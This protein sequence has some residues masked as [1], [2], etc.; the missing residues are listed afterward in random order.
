LYKHARLVLE[1]AQD[2][3][4]L[5]RGAI[6]FS[7]A[8]RALLDAPDQLAALMGVARGPKKS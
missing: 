3:I 7:G 4:L 1:L 2:A 5:D 6:V 8:S